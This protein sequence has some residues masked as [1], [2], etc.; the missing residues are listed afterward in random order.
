MKTS[1]IAVLVL[2]ILA[3]VAGVCAA[4]LLYKST[5]LYPDP[6]WNGIDSI[7]QAGGIEQANRGL[8]VG[9]NQLNEQVSDLNRRAAWWAVGAAVLGALATILGLLPLPW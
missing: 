5:R 7:E 9:Q 8:I 2:A 3:A 1:A 6:G 4:M